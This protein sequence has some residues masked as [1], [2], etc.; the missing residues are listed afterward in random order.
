MAPTPS[1]YVILSFCFCSNVFPQNLLM[2]EAEE[3]GFN[4]F[5][6]TNN[7]KFYTFLPYRAVN[8]YSLGYKTNR[9]IPL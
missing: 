5:K 2:M 4:P 9:L 1:S 3:R 7:L 8:S 6:S